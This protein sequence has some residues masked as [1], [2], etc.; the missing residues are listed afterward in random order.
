VAAKYHQ[1]NRM[2]GGKPMPRGEKGVK[3]TP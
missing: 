1:T 2:T 3:Q